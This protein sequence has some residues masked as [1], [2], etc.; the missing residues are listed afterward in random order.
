MRILLIIL[1]IIL[2]HATGIKAQNPEMASLQLSFNQTEL[3]YQRP[4]LS[5]NLWAGVYVGL[6]NQDINR[7]FDDFVS[8]FKVGYLL[9][10]R[11]KNQV[12][13]T[14]GIGLYVPNNSYYKATALTVEAG[15]RYSRFIDKNKKHCLL[16]NAGYRYGQRDYK[17]SYS[18]DV[19]NA[20]TI[21]T[22]RVSP[23]VFSIGYGF[24]I[25]NLSSI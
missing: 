20:S 24:I 12:A 6:G 23:F 22:F 17:Q 7:R 16:V 5:E 25:N 9:L 14:G 8:G 18:S 2:L 15:V 10:A 21:G 11:P 3:G 19:L 13:L 1:G 4:I